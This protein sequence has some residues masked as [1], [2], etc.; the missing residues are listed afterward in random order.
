[1]CF[2]SFCSSFYKTPEWAEP[3]FEKHRTH[4]VRADKDHSQVIFNMN[5]NIKEKRKKNDITF[6]TTRILLK[7]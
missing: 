7:D 4:R 5:N 2:I 1:M 6:L 3:Q